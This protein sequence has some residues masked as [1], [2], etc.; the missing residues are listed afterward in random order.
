MTLLVRLPFASF[1]FGL[2]RRFGRRL[3]ASGRCIIAARR[4]L[5]T[6]GRSIRCSRCGAGIRTVP[7]RIGCAPVG[8][9]RLCRACGRCRARLGP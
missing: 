2:R 7:A 4:R 5:L 8:A 3:I 9:H 1:R 6:R